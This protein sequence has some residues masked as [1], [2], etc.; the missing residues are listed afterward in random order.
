MSRRI[1]TKFLLFFIALVVSPFV[2]TQDK[3]DATRINFAGGA[4]S[5]GQAY[6]PNG[7]TCLNVAGSGSG[8][9]VLDRQGTLFTPTAAVQYSNGEPSVLYEGSPQILTGYAKVFKMWYSAGYSSPDPVMYY[10]ESPDGMPGNWTQY[11]GNPV[12]ATGFRHGW[13]FK[14]SST[15]HAYGIPI[16]SSTGFSHWTSSDGLTWTLSAANVITATQPSW[17]NNSGGYAGNIA[18]LDDGGGTWIAMVEWATAGSIWREGIFTS[19]DAPHNVWTAYSGNPV[20]PTTGASSTGTCGGADF[21]KIGSTY[22]AAVHCTGSDGSGSGSYPSDIFAYSSSDTHTWTIL[23]SGKP[24][25]QRTTKDEG[26]QLSTSQVADP[27]FV[28]ADPTGLGNPKT[29]MFYG[30]DTN[31][32]T[33]QSTPQDGWHLKVAVVNGTIASLFGSTTISDGSSLNLKPGVYINGVPASTQTYQNFVSGSGVTVAE[34]NGTYTFTSS[35]NYPAAVTQIASSSASLIFS[36]SSHQCI[37]SANRDYQIRVSDVQLSVVSADL[38]MKISTDGGTTWIASGYVWSRLYNGI[39]QSLTGA[40]GGNNQTAAGFSLLAGGGSSGPTLVISGIGTL[41]D[42]LTS[43]GVKSFQWKLSNY[44][45]TS[46]SNWQELGETYI[47]ASTAVNAIQFI[48][49]SGN[50]ASGYITCQPMP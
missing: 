38:L 8:L 37:T 35:G 15:Y 25:L 13:V 43:G 36:P 14:S 29:Y 16:G 34:S 22:Y 46:G 4:C 39:T 49:T 1:G 32:T 23:N 19:T 45:S 42:P 48:P 7:N 5:V 3:T 44:D 26:P 30:A 50:I 17:M 20:I 40:F 21:K 6:G 33:A 47:A 41:F 9:A 11:S 2:Y 12:L 27:F 31:G 24:I 10:A 28:E 18:V